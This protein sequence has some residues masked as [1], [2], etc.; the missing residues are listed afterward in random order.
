MKK[1]VFIIFAVLLLTTSCSHRNEAVQISQDSVFSEDSMKILLIDF[2][3]T[4]SVLRQLEHD[5]KDVTI[6]AHHYYDLLLKKYHSD[7]LKIT[8]SYQYWSQQPE[9]MKNI[10][11]KALDSLVI[12]EALQ[13]GKN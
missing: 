7:T 10:S 13:S 6:Y 2:Y 5:G 3:L 11:S 12:V 9:K 4:E 8:K 1:Q